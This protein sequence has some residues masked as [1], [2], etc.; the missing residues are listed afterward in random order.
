MKTTDIVSGDLTESPRQMINNLAVLFDR[1]KE[2]FLKYALKSYV[3]ES[4]ELYKSKQ[5][6]EKNL[7]AEHVVVA[8]TGSEQT[9]KKYCKVEDM[10]EKCVKTF[11]AALKAIQYRYGIHV[12]QTAGILEQIREFDPRWKFEKEGSQFHKD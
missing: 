8:Y 5:R 3:D 1:N 2:F 6:L 10:G 9:E 12:K 7:E 4:E 11:A